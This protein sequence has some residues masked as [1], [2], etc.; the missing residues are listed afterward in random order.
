MAAKTFKQ[1]YEALD[2]EARVQ[3]K[4]KVQ[5]KAGISE[6]T[7]FNWLNGSI[8]PKPPYQRIITVLLNRP[9]AFPKAEQKEVAV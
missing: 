6:K 4:L 2:T 3:L 9:T 8:V 1:R 5:L 7:F